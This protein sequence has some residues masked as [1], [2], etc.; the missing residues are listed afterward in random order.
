M[1]QNTELTKFL[2]IFTILKKSIARPDQSLI[3]KL[4]KKAEIQKLLNASWMLYDTRIGCFSVLLMLVISL[5]FLVLVKV[6]NIWMIGS[7][8]HTARTFTVEFHFSCMQT[9]WRSVQSGFGHL[10]IC[11][12][13]FH[14]VSMIHEFF[15]IFRIHIAR[16]V[17]CLAFWTLLNLFNGNEPTDFSFLLRVKN[18]TYSLLCRANQVL[19]MPTCDHT[20]NT[21]TDPKPCF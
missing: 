7:S 20:S 1:R 17:P 14:I 10:A 6:P 9:Y 19:L 2:V 13:V 15:A 12:T 16:F 11:W 3:I 8:N 4:N 18:K 5:I 21:Q